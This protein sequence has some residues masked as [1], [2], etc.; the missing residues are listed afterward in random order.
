MENY[1]INDGLLPVDQWVP[2]WSKRAFTRVRQMCGFKESIKAYITAVFPHV[3]RGPSFPD[4]IGEI[5]WRLLESI[6][7][8]TYKKLTE[9]QH[10]PFE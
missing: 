10:H 7:L 5:N 2:G 4:K 9:E 3:Q 6:D 8:G 1:N